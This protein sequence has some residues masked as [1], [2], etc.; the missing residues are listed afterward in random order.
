MTLPVVRHKT[1]A[2]RR[3]TELVQQLLAPGE[4]NK[5]LQEELEILGRFLETA[6]FKKLRAESEKR[7]MEGRKVKFVVYL[8]NDM[9]CEMQVT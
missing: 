9:K 3:H 7:F 4:S 2:K 8:D 1:V 6:D 5:E